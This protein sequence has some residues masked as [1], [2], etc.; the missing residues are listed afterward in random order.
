MLF[1][2]GM[3]VTSSQYKRRFCRDL[4]PK[5]THEPYCGAMFGAQTGIEDW[6]VC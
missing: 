1:G 5:N 2:L 3:G 4:P 6:L